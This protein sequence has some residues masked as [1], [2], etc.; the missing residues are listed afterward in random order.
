MRLG[1]DRNP[2]AGSYDAAS[3]WGDTRVP[4]RGRGQ[5]SHMRRWLLAVLAGIAL[6]VLAEGAFAQVKR[7][8]FQNLDTG[9]TGGVRALAEDADGLV[10]VGGDA[11]L[12]RF[13]GRQM[14]AI[15][16]DRLTG[17]VN[18]LALQGRVRL[19]IGGEQGLLRWD[20]AGERLAE[21]PCKG[22]VDGIGQVQVTGDGVLGL[23]RSGLYRVHP[24]TLA[25]SPVR[26]AGLPEG[27]PVE[28][29]WQDDRQLWLAIRDRG[30][31][32]CALPCAAA[33]PWAS[34]LAEERIRWISAAPRDGLYV[35]TH[36]RGLF[37]LDRDGAVVDHWW[38]G[39]DAP[40]DRA[41][42]TNGVMA[43]Q[44]MPDGRL[45]AGLWAGGL[46]EVAADGAVVSRSRPLPHEGTS[47]AGLNVRAL[48]LARN[49]TLWIGHENGLSLL[50]PL[51]NRSAWIGPVAEGQPGVDASGVSAILRDGDMLF[52][53]T[54]RGG[55]NRVDLGT[56]A[57][58]AV[59]HDPRGRDS[60]PD[61]AIWD[62]ADTGDG[63]LML[64]TSGGL[65]RLSKDNLRAETLA[66]SPVLPSDDV[67]TVARARDGGYWLATWAGGVVRV[68]AAG[69]V[70]RTWRAAD[71]LD[72]ETMVAVYEDARGRVLA[73]NADGLFL[74]GRDGRFRTVEVQGMHRRGKPADMLAFHDAAD[75]TLWMGAASGGLARWPAAAERPAW[76]DEPTFGDIGINAI[77]ARAGGG[78][79]L[80]SNT[81]LLAVDA[82]GRVLARMSVGTGLESEVVTALLGEEGGDL[83]V[84]GASGV[85][86]IEPGMAS[87]ARQDA[88][89]VISGVRLFNRPLHPDPEGALTAS[90]TH[91][92][93]LRLR[94][95]QD[96]LTLDFALPGLPQPVG[97]RY[98]YRLQGFAGDWV[99]VAADE[100][101]AV[102]TRLPPGDYRFQVQAGDAGRWSDRIA[103]L[104]VSVSPPWWMTWWARAL[105]VLA[106]MAVLASGY[107]W[108]TVQLRRQSQVLEQTVLER[109]AALREANQALQASA[110]TDAL[111]GLA[112]RRGFQ[113]AVGPR[114]TALTGNA[115][116]LLA[117]IDHFKAINDAFG[118]D[119]GDAV[120]V[121]V[122]KLLD[123]V[124][125]DGDLVARWGGEEFLCLLVGTDARARAEEMRAAVSAAGPR[126]ALGAT[127]VSITAGY[128]AI[129][130]GESFQEAV[131]RADALLYVGKR[132]G[133]NRVVFE[134]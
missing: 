45:H 39:D 121:D 96:M 61:D 9:K 68:D 25:C 65:A 17:P 32:R 100:P 106:I 104:P 53:G 5:A 89:P 115:A 7:N 24:D 102:Y 77:Q 130:A 95:D 14:A 33:R 16:P 41:F 126:A 123:A 40:A 85:Q 73:S 72:T 18:A 20:L 43:L 34:A 58:T 48:L 74:L 42:T 57:V 60:L 76:V 22:M 49:G 131:R 51:R 55:V 92:G 31:W 122:G 80:G 103:E 46:M 54:G 99:E 109:T 13:D 47:L 21:A 132:G 10:W 3:G 28:R 44:A 101:R 119:I 82:Q 114:W 107:R 4:D 127:R 29:F 1:I 62:M 133:R 90:P 134:D 91:G 94:Y 75:G 125:R 69:G 64:A 108:R 19:W 112:N 110:R 88:A 11:G 12:A 118:H 15:A 67:V 6:L 23:S 93:A 87:V 98:R 35:G 52:V 81:G 38:R 50:D 84:G 30:L 111:T 63:R 71:G 8:R 2:D 66:T 117:D 37:R 26:I 59:Q 83:W 78:L 124:A 70:A 36:R 129:R 120:L 116:L 86:R 97:L 79:W 27:Q 105:L 113:D 56:G 128:A